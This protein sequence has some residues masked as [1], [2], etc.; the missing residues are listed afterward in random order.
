M[1]AYYMI[2]IWIQINLLNTKKILPAYPIMCFKTG[3]IQMDILT[4]ISSEGH[5]VQ[6]L[7][8]LAFE[9]MSTHYKKFNPA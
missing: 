6:S 2:N 8:Q 4:P 7:K 3:R 5:T 1:L 9:T